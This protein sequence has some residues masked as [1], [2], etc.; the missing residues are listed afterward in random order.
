[1]ME[2]FNGSDPE[3]RA[4]IGLA[5]IVRKL[6]DSDSNSSWVYLLKNLII[7]DSALESGFFVE[8]LAELDL[9]TIYE[10]K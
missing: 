5:I 2:T 3:T 10:F 1:M 4:E 6:N 7:L 8:E 9:P